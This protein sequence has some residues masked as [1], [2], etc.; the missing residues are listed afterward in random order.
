MEVGCIA[1]C[2]LL[3]EALYEVD[4]CKILHILHILNLDIVGKTMAIVN[5]KYLTQSN[6]YSQI[7]LFIAPLLIGEQIP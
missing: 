1:K 7:L 5:K 6:L 2:W 3:I 4:I